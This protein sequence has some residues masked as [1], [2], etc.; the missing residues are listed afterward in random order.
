M[1][2]ISYISSLPLFFPLLSEEDFILIFN[3]KDK[4][5]YVSRKELFLHDINVRNVANYFIKDSLKSKIL[6]L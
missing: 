3:G 6:T 2:I 5:Y 1:D 4:G